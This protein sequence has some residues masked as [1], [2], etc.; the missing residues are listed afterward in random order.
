V[1]LSYLFFNF[2][3]IVLIGFIFISYVSSS[4]SMDYFGEMD[5]DNKTNITRCVC[6]YNT[7]NIN[8][9][10]PSTWDIWGPNIVVGVGTAVL[11]GVASDLTRYD[12][13]EE[14]SKS[15]I[16]NFLLKPLGNLCISCCNSTTT[17]CYENTGACL[18]RTRKCCKSCSKC[19][20][21]EDNSVQTQ[22][23]T[24]PTTGTGSSSKSL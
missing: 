19:C 12:L 6:K 2:K 20:N 9:H 23:K 3:R 4:Y 11:S 13:E 8:T 16:W 24:N 5:Y 18:K 17:F 21:V 15:I 1:K 10:Q 14:K 22:V 7:S